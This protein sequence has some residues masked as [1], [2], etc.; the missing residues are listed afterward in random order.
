MLLL[1]GAPD[2]TQPLLEALYGMAGEL[3]VAASKGAV[4]WQLAYRRIHDGPDPCLPLIGF[5]RTL[6]RECPMLTMDIIGYDP[7]SES[8]PSALAH[9]LLSEL[10]SAR[11]APA[12]L[13]L[14]AALNRH[15]LGFQRWQPPTTGAPALSSG[16]SYLITGG[17]GGLGRRFARHLA[18]SAPGCRIVLCGRREAD[19]QLRACM[20]EIEAIGGAA[21]YVRADLATDAGCAHLVNT[22]RGLPDRPL[23][24]IVHA[25]GTLRDAFILRKEPASIAPVFAAKL[26]SLRR[27][28]QALAGHA[29]DWIVLFSS[30]A[31]AMGNIGQSDY[32]VANAALDEFALWRNRLAADG[33]RQG[34]CVSINWPLWD[35]GGMEVD[36]ITRQRHLQQGIATVGD[37]EGCAAFDTA[38]SAALD[39]KAPG[40]LFPLRASES[41]LAALTTISLDARTPDPTHGGDAPAGTDPRQWL[42]NL[43]ADTLGQPRERVTQTR[44]FKA[45]GLDSVMVTEMNE[46]LE[47]RFPG[48]S[49]TLFFE[50]DTLAEL[51]DRLPA[52]SEPRPARAETVE[53]AA[54]DAAT[55]G[56][57][58]H[59]RER[60]AQVTGRPVSK[61][62]PDSAF[63]ALGLDSVMIMELHEQLDP[64]FPGLSR[65]LFFE[66]D[67]PAAVTRRIADADPAAVIR[68]FGGHAAPPPAPAGAARA[69]AS[70]GARPAANDIA[71]I[72][73][74][75]RYPG[76]EDLDAFWE[77]LRAGLDLVQ[78]VPAERWPSGPAQRPGAKSPGYARWG[79]FLKDIDQFDPLFFGIS[80]R[81]AERTDPQERLFLETAWHA[82]ENAGY[83]PAALQSDDGDGQPRQ[84]GVYVGVMYGEYQYLGVEAMARGES[85]LSQSSY[86]SI[87]NRVSYTLDLN[88]P[89]MAVD[90]MCSSSLTAIHL[91]CDALRNGGCHAAIAG[92]VNLSLHPYKYRAL[93]Q[94][95]FASSDGRCRSFGDGGDGYVPGEG[96]GAVLL[97]TLDAALA[98]GDHIHAVIRGGH[99]NHGGRTNGYTVPNPNAQGRL[100][101]AALKRSGV[102]SRQI[103]YIEA[104][105][106]GTPLGDPIEIRGL[107]MAFG[108][109]H[110][111]TCA[112]GSLKS[113][114]GHLEAAA[115]IAALT[116]VVL[117]LK[118][119][120]LTPTLHCSPPNPNIDFSTTPFRVQT[121]LGPWQAPRDHTG[122]EQ[123]RIAGISSFG[124]GGSNAHLVVQQAPDRPEIEARAAHVRQI[125]VLSARGEA[126]LR[127]QAKQLHRA[128]ANS[129]ATPRDL[130]RTLQFGR[131]HQPHRLAIVAASVTALRDA[132][133]RWLSGEP[134]EA[135]LV[136]HAEEE[137]S[138]ARRL[139]PDALIDQADSADAARLWV[140]GNGRWHDTGAAF[141]RIPLPGTIWQR[142]R[143]WL[144]PAAAVASPPKRSAAGAETATARPTPAQVLE[145]YQQGLVSHAEAERALYL[146]EADTGA[147][148]RAQA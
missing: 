83:T 84:V 99:I 22:L 47:S 37:D 39:G 16:R 50:V 28:D 105:G 98:D 17:A 110:G 59:L 4:R 79:S 143:C 103:N 77:S 3:I 74:A 23:A 97:K 56:L 34:V 96:V 75:G 60:I 86:A 94:L 45:L 7:V 57:L 6:A 119:R 12:A 91:A 73:L 115:G 33:R 124:A 82:L 132:L 92:G 38:L 106:T 148:A 14:D 145:L 142:R 18:S 134:S 133:V 66:C 111:Q 31:A 104:H 113:N 114:L 139:D 118:H 20:N 147:P 68:R 128:L 24:G 109:G 48:V 85:G 127:A 65:T 102:A 10:G 42:R 54:P 1:C 27:L 88:G 44:S 81:E 70:A 72:G 100:V 8:D 36:D 136:G 53:P 46:A 122:R 30:L 51:F 9:A 87:A 63:S 43:L 35:H 108:E 29:L 32:A 52:P 67:T 71:I 121:S 61:V 112:L 69:P 141:R 123:P 5:A 135:V 78:E 64:G 93:E 125:M 144:E 140:D 49:R 130:A 90:T 11:R 107:A 117:Q 58:E 25:A 120:E 146:L 15:L 129:A 26:D 126:L 89:S 76:G 137:R 138:D 40:Q 62:K 95:K 41:A 55:E 2:D 116:K 21:L 101:A 19:H 131:T 80:P 13:R